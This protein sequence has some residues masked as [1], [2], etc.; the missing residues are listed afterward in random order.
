MAHHADDVV[1]LD[2]SPLTTVATHFVIATARN[3]RLGASLVAEL[4]RT[5]RRRLALHPR[6]EGA[7]GD[8][9]VAL[10]CADVVVHIFSPEARA[11]YQLERLWADAAVVET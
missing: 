6:V 8:A 5:I 2:V 4:T 7:P 9:W 1:I 10:D 3:P 11:F